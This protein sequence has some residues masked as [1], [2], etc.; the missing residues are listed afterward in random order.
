MRY[1][2]LIIG[3]GIAGITA[4]ETVRERD[5]QATIGIIS[6]EPHLLYSRVLLPSFLKNRIPR[7]KL[8][9]R[10][11]DDF[12]QKRIDLFGG[13]R[14]SYVDF[15]RKE[16]G[17]GDGKAVGYEKLLLASGGSPAVLSNKANNEAPYLSRTFPEP[18]GKVRDLYRLHTL[19][20]ADRLHNDLD[21]IKNPMVVGGSFIA[22]EF[23]DIFALRRLPVNLLF[24]EPY[25]FSRFLDRAGGEMLEEN[26]R[27]QGITVNADDE[28]SEM[29]GSGGKYT[30]LT[31][32]SRRIRGDAIAA[33]IGLERN[34]EFLRGSG[35][36]LGE[37]GIKVN[38][39]LE[40]SIPGVFAAGDIAEFYDVILGKQRIIG[41]WTNAVLQGKRAGLNMFGERSPF[42]N[43]SSYSITNLGYQITAVGE[44]EAEVEAIVRYDPVRRQYERL[45]LRE[46]VLVGAALINRF[47]DKVH[48]ARLIETRTP[49][50][51]FRAQLGST[52]FD[53]Y[54][55]PPLE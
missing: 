19:D 48:I 38:E 1:D 20:D 28:L 34:L 23:L 40:T 33:G 21:S 36:E 29:S 12:T 35:V 53:I 44:C 15:Q 6:V 25:F 51:S 11:A 26:F 37:R 13:K 54:K 41:N 7:E 4:A 52:E 16:A 24:R 45:C 46:G 10:T 47:Q 30:V 8:F 27:R 49:L 3:G 32:R 14:A 22:L 9:L 39:Y 2:Y 5:P 31:K 17:L 50:D 42:R 43:V 18:R 55:I